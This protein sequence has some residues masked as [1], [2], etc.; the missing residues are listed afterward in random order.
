M[1]TRYALKEGARP[2]KRGRAEDVG[3]DLT[4]LSVERASKEHAGTSTFMIDFGVS[5]EP[6]SS[7]YFE[8]VPRSSLAWI[9]FVMPNSVGVIDPNYRGSL[10]MPLIYVGEAE[11]ADKQA[12]SLVGRRIAQLVLRPYLSCEFVEVSEL[13]ETERAEQGF[14]SSGL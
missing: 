14:G 2:P 3:Y 6:P 12:R 5:V 7:H 13:S 4:V 9:G 1:M 10:K 11:N 8:L